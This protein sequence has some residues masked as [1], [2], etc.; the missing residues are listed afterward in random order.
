MS[1]IAISIYN[2]SINKKGDVDDLQNLGDFDNGI[3][4]LETIKTLP[5]TFLK[6]NSNNILD[7]SNRR[8]IIPLNDFDVSGRIVSGY[9]SSGDYGYETPIAT[10]NGDII[11]SIPKENSLMRQF[12]FFMYVPK[13][14]KKGYLLIQRFEN[15]GVYTIL[16]NTIRKVFNTYHS[17]YTISFKPQATDNSETINLVRKGK[18]SKASF[19]ISKIESLTSLIKNENTNDNFNYNDINAEVVIKAKNRRVLNLK[20]TLINLMENGKDA[21]IKLTDNNIPYEKLKVYVKFNGEEKMIDLS[22][23]DTFSRDIDITNDITTDPIT[24]LPTKQSINDVCHQI[25]TSFDNE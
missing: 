14:K 16:S 3:D 18:I 21:K 25:L 9:I 7:D 13:N 20:N 12:Y 10:P 19:G 15:F 23:W 5:A 22:K 11:D 6:I 24:G 8:T 17:K 4:F 1:K 2:F